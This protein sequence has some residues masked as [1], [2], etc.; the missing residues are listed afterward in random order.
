MLQTSLNTEPS[1]ASSKEAA[2]VSQAVS[3]AEVTERRRTR[4]AKRKAEEEEVSQ[5]VGDGGGFRR[6]S[7]RKKI[8]F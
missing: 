5:E 8:K 6:R 3:V 7:L 1:P 2:S 4:G